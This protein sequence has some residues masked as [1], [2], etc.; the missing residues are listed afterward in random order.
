MVKLYVSLIQKGYRTI[1]QVPTAW[2]TEVGQ[3]LAE[4]D[5]EA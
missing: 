3:I 4:E 2:K 5:S 1:E